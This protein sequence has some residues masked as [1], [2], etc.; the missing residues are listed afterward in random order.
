MSVW[1]QI[2]YDIMVNEDH[3]FSIQKYEDGTLEIPQIKSYKDLVVY[4]YLYSSYKTYKWEKQ[5]FNKPVL[6]QVSNSSYLKYK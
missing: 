5:G 4:Q 2:A 6:L 3:M 1:K